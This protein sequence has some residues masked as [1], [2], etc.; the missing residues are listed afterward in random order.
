MTGGLLTIASI[1]V[2]ARGPSPRLPPRAR[3]LLVLEDVDQILDLA[4]SASTW[5]VSS[6]VSGGVST[7]RAAAPRL[8]MPIQLS[9]VGRT[10]PSRSRRRSRPRALHLLAGEPLEKRDVQPA[11]RGIVGEQVAL[12][13]AAGRDIGFLADEP[14]APV[15]GAGGRLR[16]HPA[17]AVG[18]AA[19][20]A[21]AHLLEHIGLPLLVGRRRIGLGDV[22]AD[23][24]GAER[25][26]HDRREAGEPQPALDEADGEAEAARDAFDVAP[27]SIS[28]WKAR[29]SSAG[30]C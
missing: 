9:S 6:S 24:A 23:L 4:S 13:P 16:H 26:E 18:M 29:H 28:C 20:V 22:E 5:S 30:S 3:R 25:L 14:R 17:D 1:S 21:A 19:H 11:G 15:G 12:D 27:C 8:R 10:Q 2:A 7:G